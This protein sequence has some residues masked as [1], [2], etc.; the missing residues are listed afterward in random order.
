MVADVQGCRRFVEA[1][2]ELR[3]VRCTKPGQRLAVRKMRYSPLSFL[4][5]QLR[6]SSTPPTPSGPSPAQTRDLCPQCGT[7]NPKYSVHCSQCGAKLGSSQAGW[8]HSGPQGSLNPL[9]LAGTLILAVVLVVA[10]SVGIKASGMLD[11]PA[12]TGARQPTRSATDATLGAT[13]PTASPMP[14]PSAG[15]LATAAPTSAAQIC[16]NLSATVSLVV[17][18]DG[19]SG[20]AGG[21]GS[22]IAPNGYILTNFHVIAN[23]QTGK[24]WNAQQVAQVYVTTQT[25]RP[26]RFTY[27]ARIAEVDARNDLAL[28]RIVARSD[29]SA[30]PANLNLSVLPIGDSDSVSIGD[31]LSIIGYPTLG[32][33]SV[34]CNKGSISG[35]TNGFMKTDAQLNPGNSGGSA[36]NLRGELVGV[37]T[38]ANVSPLNVGKVGLIQPV[39]VARRLINLAVQDTGR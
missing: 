11:H 2:H 18:I 17:P 21:S 5:A 31:E 37:P 22:V 35:F 28:L 14:S 27:L 36:V 39:N 25:S 12:Q 6:S 8:L 26:P 3:Q 9:R 20:A 33:D 10:I 38:A 16:Q 23:I 15:L 29:G 4:D 30:L 34:T 32:G 1:R 19:L 13:T 7:W 24:P